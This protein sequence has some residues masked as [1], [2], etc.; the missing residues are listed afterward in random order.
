MTA[1]P[2]VPLARRLRARGPK[3]LG[4]IAALA[5]ALAGRG[6]EA[7]E[8]LAWT[9]PAHA[10][11]L[12]WEK[13]TPSALVEIDPREA[14]AIPPGQVLL[15]P[16][17]TGD[18]LEI[19]GE[20][21]A[22]GLASGALAAPDVITWLPPP[23]G[24]DA[25]GRPREVIVPAW[26]AA[27]F[28]AVRGAKNQG[29]T[30]RVR[31][32]ARSSEPLAWHRFDDDIAAWIDKEGAHRPALESPEASVIAR[33]IG[34]MRKTLGPA[35]STPAGEAWLMAK[36]LEASARVRPLVEPYF[37]KRSVAIEGGR[38]AAALQATEDTGAFFTV[39]GGKG[40]ASR[41]LLQ[42][43]TGDVLR[44]AIRANAR[45]PA[46]VVLREGD[47]AA[48]T[49]TWSADPR[50]ATPGGWTPP[51]WVRAVVPVE[52][53]MAT[54][55][56]LEG[57]VAVAASAY[58]Q[59]LS[60]G[61]WSMAR[62]DRYGQLDRALDVADDTAG[63][64]VVAEL[65]AID[66]SGSAEVARTSLERL[67]K[68][69]LSAPLRA[70]VAIEAAAARRSPAE[71]PE[72]AARAYRAAS[73]LK[74]E[75][76]APLVRA[77][78]ERLAA[79]HPD[80][81]LAPM[82]WSG[83]L[84]PIA[85]AGSEDS[86]AS[87]TLAASIAPPQDGLRPVSA[88]HAEAF[89]RAHSD[90][91]DAAARAREAWR[92]EAPYVALT[93][94]PGTPSWTTV[95]APEGPID[96][97]ALCD[98]TGP[99]GA[100]YTWIHEPRTEITVSSPPG[101]HAR[102][103]F[104]GATDEPEPESVV[105][106]DKVPIAVHAGAGLASAVAVAPGPRVIERPSGAPPVMAL[107][108]REGQAPCGS[109]RDLVRWARATPDRPIE[110]EVPQPGRETVARILI[111][112][113][114][115]AKSAP[116]TVRA[117]AGDRA[118][119]AW[120]REGATGPIEI[121]IP[122]N[123]T[124]LRVTTSA[125]V[126]LRAS[127]RVHPAP[128][129]PVK[130]RAMPAAPA[131]GA[132][133]ALL[134]QIRRA[135]RSLE[136]APAASRPAFRIERATA[137][138]ALGF[139]RLAAFDR[140][141][142]GPASLAPLAPLAADGPAGQSPELDTALDPVAPPLAA[143][144]RPRGPEPLALPPGSPAVVPLGLLPKIPPLPLPADR[145][146]LKKMRSSAA[147]AL[148]V[149]PSRPDIVAAAL[150]ELA[151]DARTSS[152]ADGLLFAILASRAGLPRTGAEIL[153]HIGVTHRSGAALSRAA[154]L[155]ADAAVAERDPSLS[156][157]SYITA[158]LASDAGEVVDD[159]LARLAGGIAWRSPA[160]P[161][162]AAGSTT[163]ERRGATAAPLPLGTR[164]RRAL[165]D[166]PD[167]ALL[168][169]EGER[170]AIRLNQPASL[171]IESR[172]HALL[173]DGA[174]CSL[175]VKL[176]GARVPCTPDNAQTQ[177]SLRARCPI[178]VPAG[179]HRVEALLPAGREAIAW[180]SVTT[181][182]GRTFDASVTS[183]WIEIDPARPFAL[184]FAGPTVMRVQARSPAGEA[185]SLRWSVAPH[186]GAGASQQGELLTDPAADPAVLRPGAAP[187][188]RGEPPL[189]VTLPAEH[190]LAVAAA[191]PH[192]LRI[193]S[194]GGRSLIRVDFAIAAGLPRSRAAAEAP[195]PPAAPIPFPSA[196][197]EPDRPGP[198]VGED[199]PEGS[200]T[201]GVHLLVS[202]GNLAEEDGTQ[203]LRFGQLGLHA[204]REIIEARAWAGLRAFS[205]FR[206]G[207]P[208]FGGEL[209]GDVSSDGL[210]PGGFLRG[211]AVV[212]TPDEKPTAIGLR[213]SAGIVWSLPLFHSLS[214]AP[215]ASFT[216]RRTDASLAGELAPDRDIY[217]R[218]S[219][220]HPRYAT[221]GA[222]LHAR[223]FVDSLARLGASARTTPDV[224]GIERFDADLE[225]DILAGRG[226]WP[227]IGFSWLTSY[228]PVT[229]ERREAFVR[230]VATLN[231]TLWRWLPR[232]H[233]LVLGVE[234]SVIFDLP[235]L[236]SR[237]SP[238]FATTVTVE[239]DHAGGRALR[240][241]PPHRRPFQDRLEEE[242]GLPARSRE[243]FEP[244]W[245]ASP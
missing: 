205:R 218:Y 44:I 30:A 49:L 71:A 96:P 106:I 162:S 6:A 210:I 230:D 24:K 151:G 41:L 222:R 184:S 78:L 99:S 185:R 87:A 160:R 27:R 18:R 100:R 179:R 194:P 125:P 97:G 35:A 85:K 51:R 213:A 197:P 98:V 7:A 150:S 12:P 40:P 191:G 20:D 47:F 107:I 89:A 13:S 80:P 36:W 65:A 38:E 113:E 91:P 242:L 212:Q 3:A 168:L 175:D 60:I 203:T 223:P 53:R 114:G 115:N 219:A 139:S 10:R 172:C 140:A 110:L 126:L 135:T 23:E 66:H 244:A 109:L 84:A 224:A 173:E 202:D 39:A 166:A 195:P 199:L 161:E 93:P 76:S 152:G 145:T 239:Y 104:R 103:L 31:V 116:L 17:N 77:V 201:L 206:D 32:A 124:W 130:L 83:E 127:A 1:L 42:T 208:S 142:A 227:W 117:T 207:P 34:A 147:A 64:R 215:S 55:E 190:R 136:Q 75:E 214:L 52:S 61:D 238:S 134:D 229:T 245:E 138:E 121:P 234:A 111:A 180:A 186:A 123:E 137:L 221:F 131:P 146:S 176:D 149:D 112:R 21:V 79:V 43:S 241:L 67:R 57:E 237:S 70:L 19:T 101:T 182:S 5:V 74:P 169:T 178:E 50:A 102:L 128:P 48:R 192:L 58:R 133:D 59:R 4:L 183:E 68:M 226:V 155:W 174:G 81:V 193:E 11:L 154:S 86:I 177:P 188:A 73:A 37:T 187:G 235:S 153:E 159:L 144:P 2:N 92:R 120:V 82:P 158:Q 63:D 148:S 118:V 240:D 171:V 141:A 189:R 204:Y 181:A 211:R 243:G 9:A 8:A 225:L 45:G 54:I 165:V 28:L 167:G 95:V 233:R 119:E 209:S 231:A 15:V 22:V 228:R 132:E 72:A 198:P 163:L 105:T 46:R 164:V 14:V 16:V 156:L 200:L 62:R 216:L 236:A 56:V 33:R 129:P 108:P 157:R 25:K 170:L 90:L 220:T 196:P 69:S 29:A 232:G 94:R 143:S 217:T 26:S 122:A 88:P